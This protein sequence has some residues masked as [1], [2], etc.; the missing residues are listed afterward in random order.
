MRAA[1]NTGGLLGALARRQPLR[2]RAGPTYTLGQIQ[3]SCRSM[4]EVID[5]MS[6]WSGT[7]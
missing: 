3:A 1:S 7:S 2:L 4:V 6:G 5:R